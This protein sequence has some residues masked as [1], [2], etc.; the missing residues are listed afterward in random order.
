ML[1]T[2]IFNGR[3]A[4]V[5]RLLLLPVF[6]AAQLAAAEPS[7]V[8]HT[9]IEL[10][11]KATDVYYLPARLGDSVEGDFLLDTGS[12]YLAINEKQLK[13]LTRDSEAAYQRS[14]RARLANGS[15]RSV[16]IYRITS[17]ELGSCRLRDVEAAVL[18]GNT[19]PI[20]GMSAL[21]K[22]DGFSVSFSP[23]PR[24]RLSGCE[25]TVDTVAVR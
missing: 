8:T 15:T 1:F 2:G 3:T 14:E 19:R 21:K 18:P 5:L 13:A 12:G 25:A 23:T 22:V 9:D 20:I 16:A 24:L 17:L 7:S 10:I 6:G 4:T 11:S